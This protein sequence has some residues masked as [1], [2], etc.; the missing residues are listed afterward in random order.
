MV[1]EWDDDVGGVKGVRLEKE[2]R[3]KGCGVVEWER[4]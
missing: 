4:L 3:R 2:Q 1:K